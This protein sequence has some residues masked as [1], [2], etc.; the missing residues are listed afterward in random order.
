MRTSDSDQQC[1]KPAAA[2]VTR[3]TLENCCEEQIPVTV[4]ELGSR[5]TC[6]ARF[7]SVE[8]SRFVVQLLGGSAGPK[9]RSNCVFVFTR[10][11]QAHAFV[12][13]IKDHFT[14]SIP[15]QL[16]GE[17]PEEIAVEGR[18]TVRIPVTED[19]EPVVRLRTSKGHQLTARAADIS[20]AGIQLRFAHGAVPSIPIGA[21]TE[22]EISLDDDMASVD[23]VVRWRHDAAYGLEFVPKGEEDSFE[24]PDPLA[25]IVHR[26]EES[27]LA[28][29]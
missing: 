26:L 22:I 9:T 4:L 11:N 13:S 12:A 15:H 16:V 23:G 1:G 6:Q 24:V 19:Y 2:V 27:W 5:A 29:S 25:R 7:D 3:R 28:S 14:D 17:I 21:R 20:L 8:E 18:R 10:N